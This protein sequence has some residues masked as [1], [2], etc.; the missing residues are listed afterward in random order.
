MRLRD[1]ISTEGRARSDD[2]RI[3]PSAGHRALVWVGLLVSALFAYLAVRDVRF[4]EVKD[5]LRSGVY[6]WIV[7]GFAT[8]ACCVFLKGVRWRY[9][10][11]QEQR[12][13]LVPVLGALLVGYLFNNILPARAGE[14]ARIV[15]LNRW[16]RTSRAETAATVV[17]ERAFDVLSLLVLLFV[18]V[19]WFPHVGWLRAAA[20]LGIVLTLG[21]AAGVVVLS[22]YGDRPLRFVMRPLARLRFFDSDRAELAAVNLGQGLAALRRIRLMLAALLWTTAAWLTL[23]VSCWLIM[24]G[25]T[26][27]FR[28]APGSSSWSRRISRRSCPRRRQV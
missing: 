1:L 7:P 11:A 18:A 9:L 20:A 3:G 14:A 16:A 24:A 26:C 4:A 13:P 25:S 27:A 10:F 17:L 5:A 21:L 19:P 15:A 23:A 6:W 28:S 22:R 8:L 2:E 12:P